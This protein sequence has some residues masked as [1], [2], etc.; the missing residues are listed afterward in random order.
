M[1]PSSSRGCG[2]VGIPRVLC[3]I[4]AR[5]VAK[6]HPRIQHA[7]SITRSS[8]RKELLERYQAQQDQYRQWQRRAP[9]R[10]RDNL[11]RQLAERDS[12][13][14]DLERQVE[15]LRVSHM[16]MIRAVG[17]AGGMPKLLKLYDE[18]RQLRTELDRLAVL[19][20]GEVKPF[21]VAHRATDDK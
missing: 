8:S 6:K 2:K 21:A 3:G 1:Y 7:S 20:H 9:K 12:R 11:A 17:E 18:Y 5:A 13:I 4:T 10:S 15:V 19:P 14:A 16:A